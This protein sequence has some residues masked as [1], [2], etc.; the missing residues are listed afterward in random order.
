MPYRDSKRLKRW[1]MA[2]L[3]GVALIVV[4]LALMPWNFLKPVITD[5]IEQATGRSVAIHGD[6]E[7]SLFPRPQLALHQLEI[8]NPEWTA[9]DN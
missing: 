6:V 8:S 2:P 3:I 7:I 5:H 1:W 9:A 4:V